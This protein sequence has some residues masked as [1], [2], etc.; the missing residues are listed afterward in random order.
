MLRI[1]DREKDGWVVVKCDLSDNLASDS[2]DEKQLS[3]ACRKAAAKNIID[4]GYIMPFIT[5]PLSFYTPNSKSDLRNSR[6]ISQAISKLL[7]KQLRRRIR[8][9]TLLLKS[10]NSR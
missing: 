5:I 3:R 9:K 1:V 10:P 4:N 7:K 6:F 8:S 2:E